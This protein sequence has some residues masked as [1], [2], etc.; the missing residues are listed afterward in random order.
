MLFWVFLMNNIVFWVH[1]M[2]QTLWVFFIT[3]DLDRETDAR[4]DFITLSKTVLKSLC[5]SIFFITQ[6]LDRETGQDE[7]YVPV[8]LSTSCVIHGTTP[9]GYLTYTL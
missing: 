7:V 9:W 5:L 1:F 3:Q 2:K 8:S 4:A 6:D